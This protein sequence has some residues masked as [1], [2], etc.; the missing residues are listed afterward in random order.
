MC[1]ITGYLGSN[2]TNKV[3]ERMLRS[4]TAALRHRGPDDLGFWIEAE[5]GVGLGHRRLSILD[6]SPAGHQPMRSACCRYVMAFN[7]EVYNFADIRQELE[8]LGAAPAWRGHSDTEVILAAVSHWGFVT[9]LGKLT[10]MFAI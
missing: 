5:S 6:L 1:G 9:T 4:M 2:Q 10:G 8:K 7:G 3:Q